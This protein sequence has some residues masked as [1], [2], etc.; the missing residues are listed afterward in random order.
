MLG[1]SKE[2]ANVYQ[3]LTRPLWEA[4]LFFL[5]QTALAFLS[6][7][8]LMN[9]FSGNVDIFRW[10]FAVL[11]QLTCSE[12]QAGG[13]DYKIWSTMLNHPS[14][15]VFQG[16]RSYPMV[17]EHPAYTSSAVG[18]S[19]ERPAED[20]LESLKLLGEC[21]RCV[22]GTYGLVNYPLYCQWYVR[23]FWDV[24]IN[25]CCRQLLLYFIPIYLCNTE[26]TTEFVLNCTAI[27]FILSLDDIKPV[28]LEEVAVKLKFHE[29]LKA[30]KLDVDAMPEQIQLTDSELRYIDTSK[31]TIFD[32]Y[33]EY[34][35]ETWDSF[36]DREELPGPPRAL[37]DFV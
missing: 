35:K 12:R 3:D 15:R 6:T 23:W 32:R 20:L 16:R 8:F 29:F 19:F 17:D 34:F 14:Q 36:R 7:S 9:A 25:G 2:V 11:V 13:S 24:M 18:A 10:L 1:N 27:F 26:N 33:E 28:R 31:G 30:K 4:F 21:R 22:W 5:T 37:R